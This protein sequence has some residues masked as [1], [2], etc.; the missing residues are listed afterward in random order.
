LVRQIDIWTIND[1][2]RS[3]VVLVIPLRIQKKRTFE[4]ALTNQQWILDISGGLSMVC[5]F[6]YLHIWDMMQEIELSNEE[7]RHTWRFDQTGEFSSKSTYRAFFNGTITFEPWKRLWKSWSLVKCK[8]IMWLAIQNRC[9]TTDKLAK[10]NLPHPEKCTLCD[11][12]EK[13]AQ[14]ILVGCA[15]ARVFWFKVLSPFAFQQA[16][17]SQVTN[18]LWNGG[19]ADR[20]PKIR[21]NVSIQL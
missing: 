20:Y 3:Y 19:G 2:P 18:S 1:R 12:E 9:W 16:C 13:T 8:K 10:R 4:E 21:K 6:E 14:H 11:H 17:Q 7:D 5:L 15:F